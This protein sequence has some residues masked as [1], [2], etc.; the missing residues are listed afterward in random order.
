MRATC[1]EHLS[2]K[3]G[4]TDMV[5]D[6]NRSFS[7]LPTLPPASEPHCRTRYWR[8]SASWSIPN[9]A[10][11]INAVP[12]L[13]TQAGPGDREHRDNGL[14]AVPL[15]QRLPAV[16]QCPCQACC[17]SRGPGM[18]A[19]SRRS[20]RWRTDRWRR[21]AHAPCYTGKRTPFA[22]IHGDRLSGPALPNASHPIG[23]RRTGTFR[24]SRDVTPRYAIAGAR[25][26]A[27]HPQPLCGPYSLGSS[28]DRLP[29]RPRVD[30]RN[31]TR[32]VGGHRGRNLQPDT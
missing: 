6:P 25:P 12:R 20:S 9:T 19:A 31:Y 24:K 21:K 5:F 17:C 3:A 4:Y 16:N 7:D 13:E 10:T 29:H 15:C 23:C 14:T 22:S 30:S 1:S 8:S 27:A 28:P 2:R 11:L 18:P 32:V 26:V